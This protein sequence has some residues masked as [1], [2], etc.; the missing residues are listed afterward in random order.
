MSGTSNLPQFQ[1]Y[2]WECLPIR[3]E[4]VDREVVDDVVLLALQLW[5]VEHLSKAATRQE[6]SVVLAVLCK[7]IAR[8]M[9]F[10]YGP[11]RFRGYWL[12]AL[13]ILIQ[14]GRAHV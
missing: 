10:V 14:I 6:E 11:E 5:P 1:R 7:D 3:R 4:A 12:L 13:R 2:V 9:D 8:I